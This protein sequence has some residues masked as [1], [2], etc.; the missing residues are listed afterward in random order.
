MKIDLEAERIAAE[1]VAADHADRM[2][3]EDIKIATMT[4]EQAAEEY[5]LA[6]VKHEALGA[7]LQDVITQMHELTFLKQ[8]AGNEVDAALRVLRLVATRKAG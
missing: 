1:V 8:D 6:V 5:R 3:I 4:V 7:Q 2:A